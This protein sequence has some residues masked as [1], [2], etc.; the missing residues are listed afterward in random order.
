MLESYKFISLTWRSYISL[1]WLYL[2]N[3]YTWCGLVLLIDVKTHFSEPADRSLLLTFTI[4]F[5]ISGIFGSLC[6][7][8]EG[9]IRLFYLAYHLPITWV[10][11]IWHP[12]PQNW[13]FAS[14]FRG[15]CY[16]LPSF[17]LLIFFFCF[18][19]VCSLLDPAEKPICCLRWT[20][21]ICPMIMRV[22]IF[23]N[24]L[25]WI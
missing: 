8:L 11:T 17:A 18:S 24:Y 15:A 22:D 3:W 16:D 7:F 5:I 6:S 21:L 23:G 19:S 14:L 1:L 20:G 13:G 25:I 2:L 4:V 12:L 10:L 9:Y